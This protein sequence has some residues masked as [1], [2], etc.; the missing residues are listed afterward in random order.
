MKSAMGPARAK[1]SALDFELR[2]VRESQNTSCAVRDKSLTPLSL[3]TSI[4]TDL[5]LIYFKN[6][7]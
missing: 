1:V 6:D 2:T 5:Q 3:L 4:P 7:D